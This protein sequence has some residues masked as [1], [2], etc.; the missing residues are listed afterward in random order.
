AAR[1]GFALDNARLY[2]DQRALAEQLQRSLLT[3]PPEPDHVQIVARYEP[4]AEAA[5]IGGD[6]YDAFLQRDGAAVLVIGDVVGHDYTA[7]DGRQPRRLRRRPARP[8][9]RRPARSR[10]RE[11]A[12]R[13]HHHP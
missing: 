2:N 4:A 5:Q 1:A 7:A 8:G 10:P 6:W 3:E 12:T 9:R 11:R 13:N